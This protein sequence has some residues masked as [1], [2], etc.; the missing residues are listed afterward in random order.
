MSGR[1]SD[2]EGWSLIELL[3][4]MVLMLVVL[5][6]TLTSFNLFVNNTK[7][8]AKQNDQQDVARI[9]VDQA[10][11]ELRNLANPTSA[12]PTIAYA[13]N[14]KLAFQTTDPTKQWVMYCL[15]TS[16]R[17]NEVLWYQITTTSAALSAAQVSGCPNFDPVW[18]T[19]KKTVVNV[20]NQRTASLDRPVFS[21]AGTSGPIAAPSGGGSIALTPLITRVSV[22]LFVDVDPLKSPAELELASGAFMR[23]QNQ[24]PTASMGAQ[25]NGAGFLMDGGTSTDPESR[26]LQFY[27]F[28]E[29]GAPTPT[30]TPSN[31]TPDLTPSTKG[32]GLTGMTEFC[33]GS[34]NKPNSVPIGGLTWTCLG[35]GVLLSH[36]FSTGTSP[37]NIWLLVVDPGGLADLSD[38]PAGFGNCPLAA[39]RTLKSTCEQVQY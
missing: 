39:A 26:T 9:A 38:Q 27:W 31:L 24:V 28:S 21:Y 19:R 30:Q 23:N 20:T 2:E 29:Q 7:A 33:S 14:Y 10:V 11:R 17:S 34:A 25:P 22:D 13:D 36:T 18:T 3:V 32:S 35:T 37:R 6:A 15:D 16:S 12:V 5:S 1:F 4:A 8:N